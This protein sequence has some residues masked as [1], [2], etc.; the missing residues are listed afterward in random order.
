VARTTKAQVAS[1]V[2]DVKA[3]AL[4][5]FLKNIN[6]DKELAGTVRRLSDPAMKVPMLETGAISLDFALGGGLPRGKIIEL[7]GG[8]GGGKTTLALSVAAGVQRAGGNVA[9]VDSENGF[10]PD[11]GKIMGIDPDRFVVFQPNYGEEAIKMVDEM[12]KSKAFDLIIVDSVAAM[13]PK[14]EIDGEVE[15]QTM[16]LQ[17]RLMSKFMRRVAGITNE[18]GTTL[19]L[20]NQLRKNLGGY[21]AFD[22]TTGGR[23]IK[24]Y[25]STR[26]EV[27]TLS[28]DKLMNG[29]DQYGHSVNFKIAKSR[30]SKPFQVGK[31]DLIYGKGIDGAGSLLEVAVST[32]VINQSGAYYTEVA[33]GERL[34][35]VDAET[36]KVK[37]VVGKDNVKALLK[38]DKELYDRILASV[39]ASMDGTLE[40]VEPEEMDPEL[41]ADLAGG[42]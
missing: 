32:G 41:E 4:D 10:N 3:N 37:Q 8:E 25:A 33:T 23:A 27:K 15:Q 14:A 7:F 30:Y 29:K 2:D 11:L 34:S 13:T 39:Q 35:E 18:T 16:G 31:F 12:S 42:E 38:R 40:E 20:I 5:A 26:I 24:F 9:L 17:A 19:L 28:G 21:V 36:G 22:E 1:V 6:K